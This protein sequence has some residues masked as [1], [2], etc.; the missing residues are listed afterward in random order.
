VRSKLVVMGRRTTS[1]HTKSVNDFCFLGASACAHTRLTHFFF[2]FHCTFGRRF[3]VEWYEAL[4]GDSSPNASY[5]SSLRPHTLAAEG[6]I[7]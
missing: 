1:E 6:L 7:D 5:N 4:Y 3:E 2:S